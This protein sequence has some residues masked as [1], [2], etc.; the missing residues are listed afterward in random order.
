MQG[1][2]RGKDS[3]SQGPHG[4][5]IVFIFSSLVVLSFSMSDSSLVVFLFIMLFYHIILLNMIS[6]LGLVM[7][8][9]CFMV[10][11]SLVLVCSLE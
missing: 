6:W 9:L 10:L 7:S 11:D 2:I 5:I 3:S 4:E 8:I 1:I